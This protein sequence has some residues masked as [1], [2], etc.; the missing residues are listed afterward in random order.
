MSTLQSVQ[1]SQFG[2]F[3]LPQTQVLSY[4]STDLRPRIRVSFEE[5]HS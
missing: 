4:G 5:M 1:D 2:T 3:F